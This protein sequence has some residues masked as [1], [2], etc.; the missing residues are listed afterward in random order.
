MIEEENTL[1]FVTGNIYKFNEGLEIFS[2]ERLRYQLKQKDI[3]TIEIQAKSLRDVASFKLNSVKNKINASFFIEDAGFFVD[4]PLGGFPGVYSSYVLKTIG[5]EGI[6]KLIDD[7]TESRVHFSAII[8]LY[9]KPLDK[10]LFFDGNI[11]GK[12]SDT[13]RGEGGF[14]FDPI[15]IPDLIPDKTFAEISTHQKNK[16]SHRGQAMK[17]L[18]SF[19]KK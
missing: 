12:I 2:K 14:G 4:V 13:I 6:L 17:K 5:N 9:F 8:S 7:F 11:T 15:F 1:Y 16:I 18:I 3:K 19:L 10:V